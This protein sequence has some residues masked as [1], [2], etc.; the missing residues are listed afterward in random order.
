[1][2]LSDPLPWVSAECRNELLLLSSCPHKPKIHTSFITVSF[3]WFVQLM[4]PRSTLMNSSKTIY[5]NVYAHSKSVLYS[6]TFRFEDDADL[7]LRQRPAMPSIQLAALKSQSCYPLLCCCCWWQS[8][9]CALLLL[10]L[11]WLLLLCSCAAAQQL[12]IVDGCWYAWFLQTHASYAHD[13][14]RSERVV[15]DRNAHYTQLYS[16]RAAPS[17]TPASKPV[18][19]CACHK[20]S[21]DLYCICVYVVCIYIWWPAQQPQKRASEFW[22]LFCILFVYL[23]VYCAVPNICSYTDCV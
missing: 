18:F 21:K 12:H 11:L 16:S 17:K 3:V 5:I 15:H 4:S 9:G 20:N 10:L 2:Y 8:G 1:M 13:L 23:C 7:P 19:R 6:E 14:T 22:R